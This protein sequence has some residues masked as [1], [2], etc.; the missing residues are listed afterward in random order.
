MIFNSPNNN[1]QPH[2]AVV[3]QAYLEWNI[4][5]RPHPP[6][7][8]DLAP[9]DY[10]LFPTLKKAIR[11]QHFNSNDKVVNQH[12]PFSTPYLKKT[13][14]IKWAER[15]ERCVR[16]GGQYFEKA[17]S[18]IVIVNVM[19][20]MFEINLFLR[21]F[22]SETSNISLASKMVSFPTRI[23]V[24]NEDLWDRPIFVHIQWT[25]FEV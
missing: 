12:T 20:A 14:N 7:S 10:W 24:T 21:K 22:W 18:P 4:K 5:V 3:I 9:C 8:P 13:I 17:P 16:L 6:Y 23:R 1:A 15:M 19:S 25:V 11:G 2:T